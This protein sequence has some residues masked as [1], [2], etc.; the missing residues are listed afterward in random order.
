[1]PYNFYLSY[2]N[3]QFRLNFLNVLKW[4][5]SLTGKKVTLVAHSMG[6]VNVLFNL[7]L[8]S[9]EDKDKYIANWVSL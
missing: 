6:N 3:N 7:N 5:Y 2:Q 4:L 8:M 9:K 1:M